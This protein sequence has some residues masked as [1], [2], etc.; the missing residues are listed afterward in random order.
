MSK[1]IQNRDILHLKR[2]VKDGGR[3]SATKIASDL[4]GNLSKPV[5]TR[6]VRRYLRDLAFEYVLKIK[7]QWVGSKHRQQH[8]DWCTRYMGLLSKSYSFR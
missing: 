1:K 3:L 8:V 2:L 6:T 5:T 4:S 7:E